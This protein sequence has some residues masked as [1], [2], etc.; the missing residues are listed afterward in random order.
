MAYEEPSQFREWVNAIRGQIPILREHLENWIQAVRT[1]PRLLW[2]TVA[3]RYTVYVLAGMIAMWACLG[4]AHSIA[5]PLAADTAPATTADFHVVCTRPECGHH[6]VIN[7]ELGFDDFPIVCP[8]CQNRTGA[9]AR[10]CNS[11]Q[12]GGRWV[13]PTWRDCVRVCPRCGQKF[14]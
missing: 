14:P 7:R 8:K 11:K 3:L 1:E 12:C 4:V 6:W 13:S 5:P 9:E 2:E 10:R